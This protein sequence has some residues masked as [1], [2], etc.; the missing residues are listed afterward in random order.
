MTPSR[1]RKKNQMRAFLRRLRANPRPIQLRG[2]I[3]HYDW[4]ATGRRALIPRLLGIKPKPGV[5]YAELWFGAHPQAPSM[6]EGPDGPV[7]LNDLIAADPKFFLGARAARWGNELPFLVKVIDVARPLSLQ[8]HPNARQAR[9]GFRREESLGI[10]RDAPNRFYRDPRPKP[11]LLIA[12]TEFQAFAGFRHSAEIAAEARSCPAWGDVFTKE[13]RWKTD[14]RA[15]LAAFFQLSPSD[16]ARVARSWIRTFHPSDP[17]GCQLR[18][19]WRLHGRHHPVDPGFLILGLLSLHRLSPGETLFLPPG[20]L[21]SYLSGSAVEVM[22]NSDNV[23]RGGLTRKPVDPSA[24][25][26]MLQPV[27]RPR[28]G[29]VEAAGWFRA[30]AVVPRKGPAMALAVNDGR[31]G[32]LFSPAGGGASSLPFSETAAQIFVRP[33]P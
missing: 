2:T 13:G 15:A 32:A 24:F 33:F 26:R 30:G 6:V 1:T 4:G 11:E 20:V 3:R 14:R 22:A 19:V 28:Q 10:P 9:A 8:V 12:L 7:P 5:T 25:L 29:L 31:A 23:V 17:R 27:G 16:V 18:R 21:H